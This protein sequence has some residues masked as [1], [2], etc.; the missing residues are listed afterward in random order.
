MSTDLPG[1]DGTEQSHA[2]HLHERGWTCFPPDQAPRVHAAILW[3]S[4][5]GAVINPLAEE[6][7]ERVRDDMNRADP[8]ETGVADRVIRHLRVVGGGDK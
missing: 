7:N 2:D 1:P 4:S 5:N 8:A 3:A 6:W